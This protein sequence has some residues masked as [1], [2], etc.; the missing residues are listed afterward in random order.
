MCVQSVP[1]A[2]ERVTSLNVDPVGCDEGVVVLEVDLVLARG[3]LVVRGLDLKAHGFQVN[4]D[5]SPG[6]LAFVDRG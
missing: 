2:M 5:V 1:G 4:D 3:D 6:V